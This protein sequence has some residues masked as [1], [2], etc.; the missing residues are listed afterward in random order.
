M[1]TAGY[2]A[3]VRAMVDAAAVAM[4]ERPNAAVQY[5]WPQKILLSASW[6]IVRRMGLVHANE[7]G[8]QVLD[9]MVQACRATSGYNPTPLMV[10]VAWDIAKK[11]PRCPSCRYPIDGHAGLTGSRRPKP[12]DLS[13][14]AGCAAVLSFGEDLQLQPA[15]PELLLEL[16]DEDRQQLE[17]AREQVRELRRQ[18]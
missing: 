5:G 3:Q 6:G 16:E 12:G 10:R 1:I 17:R 13:I 9:A 18:A 7:D 8:E 11:H 2:E 14:C 15:K 4:R